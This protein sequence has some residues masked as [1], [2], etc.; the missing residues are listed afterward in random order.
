MKGDV[1]ISKELNRKVDKFIENLSSNLSEDKET[2]KDF[3]DEMRVNFT[4]SIIELIKEGHSEQEAFD[5]AVTKF[6]D[7]NQLKK[8][9]SGIFSVRSKINKVS[10]L[11]AIISLVLALIF[12]GAHKKISEYT[13][14]V[15]PQDFISETK[16]KVDKGAAIDEA[17]VDALLN[18]YKKKFEFVALYKKENDTK[19]LQNIY[20][21][22]FDMNRFK[23][24]REVDQTFLTIYC[25]NP[26]DEYEVVIGFHPRHI[27]FNANYMVI[28]SLI[29][30]W[31]AFGVWA[32]T[33]VY[34]INR[35]NLG[36]TILFFIFN[37]IGYGIFL[38]DS[39]IR[40]KDNV[41]LN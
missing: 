8:D 16:D 24:V 18:K 10:L 22:N 12:L 1:Q 4:A 26:K 39:K 9:L 29:I 14:L 34:N 28:A 36:W 20:P 25:E 30:Y 13:E 19:V 6:G 23:T 33:Y 41:I 5:I 3:R 27:Y 21:S 17:K 2:I 35:L 7:V 11:V 40:L 38:L 31:I 32:T 37:I 15:V